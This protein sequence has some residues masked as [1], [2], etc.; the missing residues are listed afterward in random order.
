MIKNKYTIDGVL[1]IYES[2]VHK[3]AMIA[4]HLGLPG[5]PIEASK[6]CTDK[7][8]MRQKFSDADIELSPDYCVVNREDQ[9]LDFAKNHDFP[10][11]LKPANLVKSLLVYKNHNEQELLANYENMKE[12]IGPTYKKYAPN[13]KPKIIVE[14]FMEGS[15]HSVDAF[16]DKE[17]TPHILNQVVDYQT[18]YDIGHDD[19][20]HYSRMLP[21]RLDKKTITEIQETAAAGC[22]ALGMKSSPA[23]IEIILTKKGARIVEIGARNGGYR[24][25]MHG[26]A[27]N[28]DMFRNTLLIALGEQPNTEASSN[29]PC[30]VLELFPKSSGKFK[31]ISHEKDLRKLSSLNYYSVKYTIGD[32]VGKS[33]EGYKMAA[34]L[35]LHNR[36]IYQFN[37]DLSFINN[38]VAVI[39]E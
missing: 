37:Q 35:I 11:I 36:D 14:E 39:T 3:A 9:L 5:L 38:Y 21:S 23:H 27:N 2:Y 15:I 33:S 7:A 26:L 20:F 30:A 31:Y 13:Q 18:G 34:V 28:I 25:R 1:V 32:Y 8:I 24:E 6:A 22:M 29:Y 16:I 12:L 17:G 4:D 19:N 10:L